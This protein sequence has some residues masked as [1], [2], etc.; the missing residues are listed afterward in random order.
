MESKQEVGFEL[1]DPTPFPILPKTIL[2]GRP[3]PEAF[4]FSLIASLIVTLVSIC[5]WYFD[6]TFEILA[7]SHK[8]VFSEH[9]YYRLLTSLL[10][11]ADLRHLLSNLFYSS[12]LI[13]FLV[14]YFGA[15]IIPLAALLFGALTNYLTLIKMPE[16]QLLLG[17]SG[18]VFW[19]GSLW[20]TLY[21]FLMNK[22]SLLQR[23]LRTLGI[24]LLI[25]FPSEAFDPTVSYKAHFVGFIGGIVFGII[26]YL[27]KRKDWISPTT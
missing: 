27:D 14:G 18:V 24:A 15:K 10:V 1:N 4:W 16:E 7:S 11:H 8:A 23:T 21:F 12:V 25:F 19:L 6:P 9:Q 17:F 20:L 26:L 2:D 5:Q 3:N 22:R 13:Y